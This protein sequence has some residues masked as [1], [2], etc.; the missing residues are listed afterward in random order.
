MRPVLGE[1]ALTARSNHAFNHIWQRLIVQFDRV[2]LRSAHGGHALP[3]TIRLT[4]EAGHG[5]LRSFF[6]T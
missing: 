6:G 3:T 4:R 2:K 1:L 5:R